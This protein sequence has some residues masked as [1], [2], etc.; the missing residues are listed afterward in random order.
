MIF[1]HAV[2]GRLLDAPASAVT[3]LRPGLNVLRASGC[4]SGLLA[5]EG[6]QLA[7]S[8][9]YLWLELPEQARQV[10]TL[11]GKKAATATACAKDIKAWTKSGDSTRRSIQKA[12]QDRMCK[13]HVKS[14]VGV[15]LV[16]RNLRFR[17]VA[18]QSFAICLKHLD[19]WHVKM[20]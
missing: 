15:C 13:N 4:G 19:V 2:L 7:D 5:L 14:F 12:A 16:L 20:I 11:K 1:T 9:G 10:N 3:R 17:F 18:R 6:V 8:V